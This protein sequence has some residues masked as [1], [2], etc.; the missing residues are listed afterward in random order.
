MYIVCN[1]IAVNEG[2]EAAFEDRFASRAALVDSMPGFIAFNL[3]RP[4]NQGDPYI[5]M[6][7]WQEEAAFKS[8]T[9]SEAFKS[10][11]ANSRTLPPE[12]FAGRP[13]LEYFDVIQSTL[14]Q[15]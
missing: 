9:D 3:M 6:T 1:R 15:P 10:Q 11:H 4:K 14:E 5:V 13:K 2:Y 7:I 8:W 12:A